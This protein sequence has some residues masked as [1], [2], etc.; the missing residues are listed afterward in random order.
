VKQQSRKDRIRTALLWTMFGLSI[1]LFIGVAITLRVG[2]VPQTLDVV[3]VLEATLAFVVTTLAILGAFVV[4][5]TWNGIESRVRDGVVEYGEKAAAATKSLDDKIN[6]IN[7]T[8][9]ERMEVINGKIEVSVNEMEQQLHMQKREFR[10]EMSKNLEEFKLQTSKLNDQLGEVE[11]TTIILA[12]ASEPWRVEALANDIF[13]INPSSAIAFHMMTSYLREFDRFFPELKSQ[14]SG[15]ALFFTPSINPLYHW[16]KALEWYEKVKRQNIPARIES[17][18]R[19]IDRRR[20]F[21]EKEYK[22]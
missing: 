8:L 14:N 12:T 2:A 15:G 13:L 19:E 6:E 18:E 10:D 4:V 21:A 3:S 1:G 5:V 22:K 7:K 16:D 9:D 17:A 20:T 11:R